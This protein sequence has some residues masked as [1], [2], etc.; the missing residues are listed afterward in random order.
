M[1]FF[2][3]SLVLV[4]ALSLAS[5][6]LASADPMSASFLESAVFLG[7]GGAVSSSSSDG[8][9]QWHEIQL[10]EK[11]VDSCSKISADDAAFLTAHAAEIHAFLRDEKAEVS[12]DLARVAS[13]AAKTL[14]EPFRGH[15]DKRSDIDVAATCLG[16]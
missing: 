5:P 7:A 15:E 12:P 10:D 9:N 4:L 6:L 2:M 13:I 3:K 11:M 1:E 8:G 16:G 14:A